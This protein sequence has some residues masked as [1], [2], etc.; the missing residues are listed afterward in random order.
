M[1]LW[2]R[3]RIP[4][5]LSASEVTMSVYCRTAF[6]VLIALPL[7]AHAGPASPVTPVTPGAHDSAE[8]TP[9]PYRSAFADYRAFDN[10]EDK[11]ADGWRAANELVGRLAGHGAYVQDDEDDG[12]ATAPTA[13]SVVPS[14]P[15]APS[16]A[17]ALRHAH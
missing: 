13:T 6:A 8:S 11:P 1:R 14:A 4:L 5:N 17:P 10:S 7:A 9:L 12:A 15:A 16:Q 2:R 3:S